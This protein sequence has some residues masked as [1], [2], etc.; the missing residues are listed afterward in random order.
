[1]TKKVINLF[2]AVL[3]G[4][5]VGVSVCDEFSASVSIVIGLIVGTLLYIA[6]TLVD[7]YDE[8]RGEN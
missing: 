6:Y 1:M 4:I 7:I 3:V 8:V 5:L 2:F